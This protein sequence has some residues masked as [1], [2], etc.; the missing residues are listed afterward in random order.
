MKKRFLTQTLQNW[1]RNLIR[2]PQYRWFVILGALLY[3][4]SPVD[5]SPDAFPVLGWLDDGAIVALLVAEVS[6]VAIEHIKSRKDK[7]IASNVPES[8]NVID[9]EATPV[10]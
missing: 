5:I 8:V 7:H 6:Q 3:V 4:V 1:L 10:S 2:H 9:V